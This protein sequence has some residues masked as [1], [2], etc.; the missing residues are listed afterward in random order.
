MINNAFE[1]PLRLKNQPSKWLTCWLGMI[2][3]VSLIL[4]LFVEL[5]LWIKLIL[6]T[7]ILLSLFY[8]LKSHVFLGFP[9]SILEVYL[10]QNDEWI[11]YRRDGNIVEARLRNGAFV[12]PK[13]VILPFRYG[14]NFTSVVLIPNQDNKDTLRRLRVRL[15]Y[16]RNITKT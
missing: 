8:N 3:S 15:K 10:N 4:L 13:M 2:H 7:F 1:L 5:A 12:H 9:G 11:L 6:V 14:M 16:R